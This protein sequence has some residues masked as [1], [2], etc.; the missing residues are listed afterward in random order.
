L[1]NISDY[2]G[3]AF[4]RPF[5]AVAMAIFMFSLAGIPITA[6][7]MSKFYVFSAAVQ[8]G[9]IWLVIL[10]VINSMISLYYYLGVVVVM[11]MQKSEAAEEE[12][13]LERLPAVGLALI[14]AIFGTIQLGI[15]PARWM[16][17][18]QDL[19]RSVM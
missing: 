5:A 19:A 1:V 10:G 12:L 8:S 4:H 15:A 18:F 9:Y 14:I 13:A 6:G 2:R 17:A 7:F 3:L 11:F 16:E